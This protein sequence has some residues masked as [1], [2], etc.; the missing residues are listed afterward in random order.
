MSSGASRSGSRRGLR[1]L[2]TLFSMALALAAV[3]ALWLYASGRLSGIAGLLLPGSVVELRGYPDVP[4]L[5]P[6][7]DADHAQLRQQRELVNA[8]ARRHVGTALTGGSLD[9]LR[10]LQEVLDRAPPASDDTY[11]LQA[12]GVALG[13]VLAAQ[14]GLSWTIYADARGQSRAL[15]IHESEVL[16][17]VTMISK[18]VEMGVPFRVEDLYRDAAET[19]DQV[20]ARRGGRRAA[21]PPLR[22]D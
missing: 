19:V 5:L 14:L 16:F 22:L 2:S 8:L 6:L 13:D 10:I 17:P 21:A 4:Q 15:K 20:R 1:W 3:V 18:R 9:D 12:F 7:S 11:R